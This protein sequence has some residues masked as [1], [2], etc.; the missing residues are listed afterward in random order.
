MIIIKKW[1]KSRKWSPTKET[2]DCYTNSPCKYL[3]KWIENII[4]NMHTDV[5]VESVKQGNEFKEFKADV[6]IL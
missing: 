6:M 3:K 2:L 4:E 5:T 1:R